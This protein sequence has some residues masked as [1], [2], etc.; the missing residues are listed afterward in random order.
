M[1][2][3]ILVEEKKKGKNKPPQTPP[4]FHNLVLFPNVFWLNH[5]ICY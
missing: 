5:A 1:Q 2:I 4:L 3:S